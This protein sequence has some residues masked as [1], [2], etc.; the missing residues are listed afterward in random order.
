MNL[1]HNGQSD[2]PSTERMTGRRANREAH[3]HAHVSQARR[4]AKRVVWGIYHHGFSSRKRV[5]ISLLILLFVPIIVVQLFYSRDALLPN[6]SVG[7]VSLS[8]M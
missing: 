6:M 5:I 1:D 8:G 2:A 4:G 7:G 3:A